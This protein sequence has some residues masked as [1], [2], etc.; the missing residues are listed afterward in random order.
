MRRL[1]PVE[2]VIKAGVAFGVGLELVEVV[3]DELGQRDLPQHLHRMLRQVVHG[4]ERAATSYGE[5]HDRADVIGRDEDLRLQVG[6]LDPLDLTGV[7]HLLRG[8]QADHLA[9]LA[10]HVILHG[11]RG[12]KQ[13]QVELA[14][15][16]LLDHFHMQQAQKAHAEAEAERMGFL[17]LPDKRRIV[18]R[19]LL[20]RLFERLVL[21]GIDGEQT[22]IAHGLGL[23]ITRQGLLDAAFGQRERIAHL[24]LGKV[25]KTGDQIPY[26]AQA[27][28]GQRLLSGMT[29]AHLFGQDDL[30]AGHELEFLA[31]VHG[32]VH[33]AHERHDAA[34]RIEVAVEDERAQRRIRV[35]LRR[36]DV[37]DHGLEQV[38][39]ANA[40]FAASQY[41]VVGRDGKAV[42]DLGL[43]A[44]GLGAG[45]IDLVDERD[46][47]K[48]G[49]HGHHG[50][51]HRLRLDALGGIDHE[52]GAFAC[53]QAAADLV[54]EVDMTRGVDEVEL[55]GLPIIG[56]I[57]DA[58]SLA[59]DGDAAF[60]L[61][62]HA[63]K[64]LGLHIAIRH[65]AGHL[66]NAVGERGLAMVDMGDDAEISDMG[67]VGHVPSCF[68][69]PYGCDG[70]TARPGSRF[71]CAAQDAIPTCT[72]MIA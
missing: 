37:V 69:M 34:I 38:M 25:L 43:D 39:D 58:N 61:D 63:V 14:L 51:R 19:E 62:V 28:L 29:R 47:L 23:A 4:D 24:H 56:G 15:Q 44:F 2:V 42:L 33:H 20:K 27:K 26:L 40:G 22:G 66:Q 5:V 52:H 67:W 48:V 6:L 13:V 41:R 60:A 49:V 30:A 54:S 11:R 10:E 59:F 65:G 32:A 57:V 53:G 71:H 35:A 46:D 64:Q 3:H 36:G 55:V 21:I 9:A 8:V 45:K 68:L 16:A 17:R 72:A 1:V 70:C 18:E 12:G 31:L 7:G 50:V